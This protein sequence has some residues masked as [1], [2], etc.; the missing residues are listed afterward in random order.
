MSNTNESLSKEDIR[1]RE[2]I[3]LVCR[4]T[5]YTK[6]EAEEKLKQRNFNYLDV[7]KEYMNPNKKPTQYTASLNQQIFKN[8]RGFLDQNSKELQ[9]NREYYNKAKSM[10]YEKVIEQR[11]KEVEENISTV[12]KEEINKKNVIDI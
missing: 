2:V 9:R 8:M 5:D 11:V 6:E 7:I 1:K 10:N 3:N 12:S 4:Q